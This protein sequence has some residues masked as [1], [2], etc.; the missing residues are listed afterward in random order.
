M[1]KVISLTPAG[2]VQI[3]AVVIYGINGVRMAFC[4]APD[5]KN[6]IDIVDRADQCRETIVDHVRRQLQDTP[7]S[8]KR[9]LNIDMNRTRLILFSKTSAHNQE[10][11]IKAF[12]TR[13]NREMLVGLKLVN[14]YERKY[15]WPR[16]KMQKLHNGKIISGGTD[17]S[18]TIHMYMVVGSSRWMK[19]PHLLSLYLLLLRLGIRGFK[20][21]FNTHTQLTKELEAFIANNSRGNG[22][23]RGD[24]AHVRVTYKKWDLLLKSYNKL[25]NKRTTKSLYDKKSLVNPGAAFSEGIRKLCDGR[26]HD[27]D[28]SHKFAKICNSKNIKME[29][30]IKPRQEPP[31]YDT[32]TTV[33]PVA[34]D[35]TSYT[36]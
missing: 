23:R 1:R 15:G 27:L 16:T 19:S 28:I 25:F 22:V 35:V 32:S 12:N 24:A 17:V 31:S 29:V 30:K 7:N 8:K 34:Y 6:Q 36:Y 4:T 26:S 21:D 2:K 14:H 33:R 3:G 13:R 5:A 11:T 9:E 20:A 10:R 18:N